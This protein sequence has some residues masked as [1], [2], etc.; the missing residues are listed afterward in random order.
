MKDISP[1]VINQRAEIWCQ[2]ESKVKHYCKKKWPY[3]WEDILS[4]GMLHF[5]CSHD[6]DGGFSQASII[7][8][9]KMKCMMGAREEARQNG[10]PQ[11]MF[12]KQKTDGGC[13]GKGL[14][15]SGGQDYSS[16]L[17]IQHLFVAPKFVSIDDLTESGFQIGDDPTDKIENSIYI[18]SLLRTAIGNM[19]EDE[20]EK[21]AGAINH[22]FEGYQLAEAA[23]KYGLHP[24][25][26]SRW[27]SKVGYANG[28][29][30]QVNTTKKII[31]STHVDETQQLIK[32]LP[33]IGFSQHLPILT[34]SAVPFS[35][36]P[37][38][39]K[40]QEL[41]EMDDIQ[42]IGKSHESLLRRKVN[43]QSSEQTTFNF[44]DKPTSGEVVS[45]KK[46]MRLQL[47][48]HESVEYALQVRRPYA[49]NSEL[50]NIAS[51]RRCTAYSKSRGLGV[52]RQKYIVE[53][54]YVS[55]SSDF[56]VHLITH[57][58]RHNSV[59]NR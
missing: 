7:A 5:L 2:I 39:L 44:D 48:A 15:N 40:Q 30:D 14:V 29:N 43:Q 19:K 4:E 52:I 9:A 6:I 27:L 59:F 47:I 53:K 21:Y 57:K 56:L 24:V 12:R 54:G 23:R 13:H 10:L 25:Y 49:R 45:T 31:D 1:E 18:K 55:E 11:Q 28:R 50:R 32:P 58:Q 33:T 34:S 26:F 17:E 36:C 51:K 8:F 3:D 16:E 38:A 41:F 22:V 37:K 46:D 35:R 42:Y 20:S